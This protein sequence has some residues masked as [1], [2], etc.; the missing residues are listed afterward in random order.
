MHCPSNENETDKNEFYFNW[1]VVWEPTEVA[2]LVQLRVVLQQTTHYRATP[3]YL[4]NG[5]H[6]D[7][8]AHHQS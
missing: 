7:G 2:S 8:G 5:K 1:F 4:L 6:Q 3:S